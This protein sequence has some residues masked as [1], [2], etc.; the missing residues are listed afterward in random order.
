MNEVMWSVTCPCPVISLS[1]R[2]YERCHKKKSKYEKALIEVEQITV[3]DG[4]G[5]LVT[6][7]K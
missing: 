7:L 4:V 5:I 6:N 3:V 2:R 1:A